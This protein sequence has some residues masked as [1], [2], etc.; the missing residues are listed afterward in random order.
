[1]HVSDCV[2]D[3]VNNNTDH[4]FSDHAG[5]CSDC[6]CFPQSCSHLRVCDLSVVYRCFP[7]SL[8]QLDVL[9][10]S[11]ASF[12]FICVGVL[13]SNL[14]SILSVCATCIRCLAPYAVYVTLHLCVSPVFATS[15]WL[16]L[17]LLMNTP[18]S[19]SHERKLQLTYIRGNIFLNPY[20]PLS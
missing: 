16:L 5:S 4:H 7:Q 12:I 13:T 17:Y 8:C 14:H 6:Q 20:N 10:L 3:G 9:Y 18:I 15:M 2:E 19:L 11:V 1:M